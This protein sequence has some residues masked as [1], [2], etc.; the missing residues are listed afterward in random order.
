MPLYD[1]CSRTDCQW[2]ELQECQWCEL[3]PLLF[4]SE[5][6]CTTAFASSLGHCVLFK[7]GLHY[8]L[9]YSKVLKKCATLIHVPSFPAYPSCWWCKILHPDVQ[10]TEQFMNL[11]FL[12]ALTISAFN[13]TLLLMLWP[14]SISLTK[15]GPFMI[16]SS[17]F[18]G[19]SPLS[20][21]L[22]LY[23]GQHSVNSLWCAGWL[24]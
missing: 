15:N 24:V 16:V 19:S 10:Y 14:A 18:A 21:Y 1:S 5:V 23:Q 13:P 9:L 2:C 8:T 17:C 20:L 4:C 6:Q 7:F 3:Q 12:Y 11:S 22:L